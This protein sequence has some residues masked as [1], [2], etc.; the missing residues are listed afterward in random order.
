MATKGEDC[1]VRTQANDTEKIISSIAR[2]YGFDSETTRIIMNANFAIIYDIE[3]GKIVIG[4]VLYNTTVTT[5]NQ[6]VDI[7]SVVV[8]QFRLALEQIGA[9]K[10]N[11]DTYRL[12]DEQKQ[13]LEKAFALEKEIDEERGLGNERRQ[14]NQY[15]K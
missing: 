15:S 9:T 5:D 3:D 12:Y 8:M 2:N 11:I 6:D 10:D 7:T 1:Y 13:L 4:D 14:C